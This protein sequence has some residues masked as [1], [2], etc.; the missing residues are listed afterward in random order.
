MTTDVDICNRALAAISTRSSI[1][2]LRETST[3]ARA[4]S[5]LY[6]ST[7]DALLRSAFWNFARST[8]NLT[9]LKAASG[10]PE[11]PTAA[12]A[13]W[14][15]KTQPALPWLYSYAYPNDAL[16][17][18]QLIPQLFQSGGDSAG[19]SIFGQ[20]G[21]PSNY[22]DGLIG[23]S[24]NDSVRGKFIVGS[25]N[26]NGGDT[27]KCILTNVE[28]AVGVYTKQ[29]PN[30][31]LWDSLFEECMVSSLAWRLAMPLSGDKQLAKMQHD[32][33]VMALQQARAADGNEG[34]TNVNRLPDWL[35]VRG[36]DMQDY[37]TPGSDYVAGY[38]SPSFLAI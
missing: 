31:A 3:E 32:S 11:N 10:T 20:A 37:G 16:A 1:A 25:D 34:T 29:C 4:C 26:N 9:V 12:A 36:A 15:P 30:P 2:S 35:A 14:D 6:G 24:S 33:A 19:V 27:V 23:V 5:L 22:P 21:G 38:S 18:R 17:M 8:A 13:Q 7:R 28:Q